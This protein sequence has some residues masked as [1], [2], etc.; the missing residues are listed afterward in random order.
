VRIVHVIPGSGSGFYCENCLRDST[1][2]RALREKGHDALVAPMYLNLPKRVFGPTDRRVFCGAV[3]MY[4]AESVP[5]FRGMPRW[6]ERVLDSRPALAL[7]SRLSGS[8]DPS[9]LSELTLSMLAGDGD[10]YGRELD[11]FVRWI[12]RDI[13]PDIIHLSNALLLSIARRVRAETSIP[14]VVSL[15]DEDTWIDVL[16]LQAAD[17]AWRLLARSAADADLFLPVSEYYAGVSAAK[18]GIAR[19]RMRVVPVGI[20]VERY[21]VSAR[22]EPHRIGF[23]SRLSERMGFGLLAEAF[24]LLKR[25][26]G[27]GSVKLA[28][29]GG[30]TGAD[31]AFLGVVFASLRRGGALADVTVH[32]G[33]TPKERMGFLSGLSALSVPAPAGEAFG[34]FLIEAAA[35][36]VP[37]VQ[38]AAGAYPEIVGS[39]GGGVLTRGAVPQEIAEALRLLLQDPARAAELAAR[40]RAGALRGYSTAAMAEAA[41]AAFQD[42]VRERKIA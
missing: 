18:L 23:L 19:E 1:L 11:S 15:Q 39:L 12:R 36:G 37:V 32:R 26:P 38:P 27:M 35:A 3:G 9:A 42:A 2:V 8:T 10:F 41:V 13:K 17:A 33:F 5:L 22:A 25:M 6:L 20:D 14:V 16:P 28:A 34:S 24:M 29:M 4:L 21:P 31:R 40:G 30:R 7:A